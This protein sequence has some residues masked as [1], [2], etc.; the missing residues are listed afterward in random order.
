MRYHDS[1]IPIGTLRDALRV[2]SPEVGLNALAE[3]YAIVDFLRT[4]ANMLPGK[5][6]G[7]KTV[8]YT[9][10]YWFNRLVHLSEQRGV[11]DAGLQQQAFRLLESAPADVDWQVVEAI[12]DSASP[13]GSST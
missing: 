6:S 3:A 5:Y 12:L 8:F 4:R 11:I 2:G 9:R 7:E 1:L 10:P 13:S